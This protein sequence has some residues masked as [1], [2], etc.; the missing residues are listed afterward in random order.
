MACTTFGILLFEK[1]EELDFV[2]PWEVFG[3]VRKAGHETRVVSIAEKEGPVLCANGLR[4]MPDYTF[5]TAPDLDVVL[6]PGGMGTRTEIDNPALIAWLR[7][8]GSRCS[9]VTSVCTGSY[10]L[11]G[12]GFTKGRRI[13]THWAFVETL[14]EAAQDATVLE[15]QRFVDD[16]NVVTAAGVSAGID[17]SLWLVGQIWDVETARATQRFMQYEPEPPYG[18]GD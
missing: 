8:A 11:H 16:G 5:A 18:E 15:D 13:T 7:G 2:G 17:M 12:A 10:L 1:V 6:V 4:V 14:R 3:A 9:W